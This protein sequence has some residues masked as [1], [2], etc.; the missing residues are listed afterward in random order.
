[1]NRP[2]HAQEDPTMVKALAGSNPS[3]G[4]ATARGREIPSAPPKLQRKPPEDMPTTVS[5]AVER[6]PARHVSQALGAP[7]PIPPAPR[8]DTSSAFAGQ[9]GMEARGPAG[10][11]SRPPAPSPMSRQAVVIDQVIQP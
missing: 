4:V 7:Q 1:P 5:G 11:I 10:P 2:P 9:Q 3:A 6:M 8:L